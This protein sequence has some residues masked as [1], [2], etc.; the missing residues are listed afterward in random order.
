MD[1]NITHKEFEQDYSNGYKASLR[2]IREMGWKGARDKTNSDC[3]AEYKFCS[4][5]AYYFFKGRIDAL[6]D[7]M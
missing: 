7:K 5:A 4:L 3:P 2:D 1:C 6:I